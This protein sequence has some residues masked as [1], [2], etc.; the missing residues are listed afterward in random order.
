MEGVPE[1][2]GREDA[3]QIRDYPVRVSDIDLFDH[4]NNSVY[5]S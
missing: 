4:M 5:W 1:T 2:R 3:N